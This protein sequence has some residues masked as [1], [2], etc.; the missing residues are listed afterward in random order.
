MRVVLGE[1]NV[2]LPGTEDWQSF[3]EG[4]EFNV[5]GDSKFQLQVPVD[6]AYLCF[7]G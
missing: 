3:K 7:Y 1:L 5:P 4:A 6:T 2:K